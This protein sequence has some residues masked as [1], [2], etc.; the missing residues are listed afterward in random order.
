[1]KNRKSQGF[2][3]ENGRESEQTTTAFGIS[4]L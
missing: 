4:I 3:E 2:P 1:M